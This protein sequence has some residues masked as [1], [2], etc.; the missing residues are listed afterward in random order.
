MK[1]KSDK[2]GMLIADNHRSRLYLQEMIKEGFIPNIALIIRDKNQNNP[3]VQKNFIQNKNLK[4]NSIMSIYD[5]I[6]H[7]KIKYVDLNTS[8]VHDEIVIDILKNRIEQ[9]F[10]FSGH[11]GTILKRSIFKTNKVFLD[12]HGGYLPEYKGSTTNYYSL[13][14]DYELG[15]SSLFLNENIDEGPIIIR[16]KFKIPSKVKDI[17]YYYDN[18]LRSKVL[19][20]TMRKLSTKKY[21]K[22]T[23]QN[24]TGDMYF[25][26][27][28]VLK[29]IALLSLKQ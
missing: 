24:T 10:I 21:I 26:I 14:M 5:L 15:A 3:S 22:L 17:D 18:H 16:K 2:F 27:H 9:I 12:V 13:I 19:V 29:H 25:I 4:N 28:P 20:E 8:N 11:G 1:I 23:K 6:L 7:K